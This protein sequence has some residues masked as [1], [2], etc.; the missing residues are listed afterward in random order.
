M[1]VKIDDI[2]DQPL[3]RP[4]QVVKSDSVTGN[5]AGAEFVYTITADKVVDGLVFGILYISFQIQ[6]CHTRHFAVF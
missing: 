3:M 5:A 1:V 4:I 2:A 6:Y